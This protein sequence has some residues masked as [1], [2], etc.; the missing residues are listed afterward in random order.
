[1]PN[2]TVE[3]AITDKHFAVESTTNPR[4]IEVAVQLPLRTITVEVVS[5]I[6]GTQGAKGDKG[7]K[8]DDGAAGAQGIQGV[9]GDKGDDGAQGIQGVTGATGAT[10]PQGIPGAKG[11]KG[12][13]GDAGADGAQGPAGAKGDKGDKGDTGA[14]GI[15]GIAGPQGA[16]GAKG[17]KGDKGDAGTSAPIVI[18]TSTLSSGTDGR[19]L[20]QDAGVLQQDASFFW[21][22]TNKRLGIGASPS[23]TSRLDVRAQGGLSTNIVF[24]LRNSTDNGNILSIAGNA[25]SILG[26]SS[27]TAEGLL[28]LRH[29]FGAASAIFTLRN[30]QY[31]NL[32]FQI[33]DERTVSAGSIGSFRMN[34]IINGGETGTLRQFDFGGNGLGVTY[35][36][37]ILNSVW[38]NNQGSV[39]DGAGSS[40]ISVSSDFFINAQTSKRFIFTPRNGNFGVNQ[41][42]F[43][44]SATNTI[45]IANGVAPTS[46]PAGCGQ[47][48]VENGSLKYRGSSGTITILGAA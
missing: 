4:V 20:F 11:D 7:D 35:G 13:K 12:D 25:Q 38:L 22:N 37:N 10:G 26:A 43:G 34:G 24:R 16:D 40:V 2:Y 31:G 46:S 19:V 14:Q 18:G 39:G 8:G 9:K 42:T 5:S 6:P 36:G 41:M 29:D 32:I 45:A 44:A 15:Q 1:M 30:G 23:S 3:V 17:D 48:Y 33:R 21:D 28:L 27:A 47:I